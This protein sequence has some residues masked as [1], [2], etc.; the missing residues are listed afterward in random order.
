MATQAPKTI[1]GDTQQDRELRKVRETVEILAGE[2]GDTKRSRSAIRRGELYPL[3]NL[4][5]LSGQVSA[6]P[7]QAEHNALQRDVAAIFGALQRISNILGN[8]T[9]PKP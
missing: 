5:L 6:A 1:G 9:L 7:T 2:R 8:A 3:A 4:K